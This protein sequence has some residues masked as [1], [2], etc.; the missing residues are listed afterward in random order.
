M[1]LDELQ[2]KLAEFEDYVQ[3]SDVAAMQ[4]RRASFFC[5]E[6][7]SDS[8][9]RTINCESGCGTLGHVVDGCIGMSCKNTKRIA[10]FNVFNVWSN[11]S[12]EPDLR[13]ATSEYMDLIKWNTLARPNYFGYGRWKPGGF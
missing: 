6:R 5:G 12:P 10:E 7:G 1:S 8:F 4:S 11:C 9:H 3:S 2:E 13:K